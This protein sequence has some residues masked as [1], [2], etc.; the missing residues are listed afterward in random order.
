MMCA[1]IYTKGFPLKEKWD[2]VRK[3]VAVL[4]DNEIN[5]VV[6]K[7]T[8]EDENNRRDIT[9]EARKEILG[10]KLFN[11]IIQSDDMNCEITLKGGLF[12]LN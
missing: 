12:T 1:D 11:D 4:R 10:E 9:P 6:D 3:L 5:D 8:A 7:S 2:E